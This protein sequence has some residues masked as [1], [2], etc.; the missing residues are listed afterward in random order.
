[1]EALIVPS[2]VLILEDDDGI[3]EIASFSFQA[4][5]MK[6]LTSQSISGAFDLLKTNQV[7]AIISD[8][9]L[10]GESGIDF[11]RKVH[12]SSL[13]KIL[14]FFITGDAVEWNELSEGADIV[15]PKFFYKPCSFITV[16]EHVSKI[17]SDRKI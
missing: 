12:R 1:M 7:D 9:H 6:T 2:T 15:P 3:L 16:A 5:G 14:F 8:I 17:L 13:G 11:Y 4:L 10:N